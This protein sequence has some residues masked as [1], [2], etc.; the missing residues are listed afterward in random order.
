M[1]RVIRL[2]GC[3]T[4]A[5]EEEEKLGEVKELR[6]ELDKANV[7]LARSRRDRDAALRTAR[8]VGR[9]RA[10]RGGGDAAGPSQPP[11]RNSLAGMC[12]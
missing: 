4:L 5:G 10:A 2:T 6:R 9:H 1:I 11:K 3:S 8:G 12:G 7:D